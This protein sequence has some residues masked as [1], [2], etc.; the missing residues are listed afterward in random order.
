MKTVILLATVVTTVAFSTLAMAEKK[1][2]LGTVRTTSG[3]IYEDCRLFSA[4]IDG[5]TVFHKHGGAK[6]AF[7]ELPAPLRQ[8]FD[9]DAEKVAAHEKERTEKLRK[10]REEFWE[11]QREVAAAE[12]RAQRE[13]QLLQQVL[14]ASSGG[15]YD[16]IFMPQYLYT[17]SYLGGLGF[18]SLPSYQGG[19]HHHGGVPF[20]HVI[21]PRP[22][23]NVK[24][25]PDSNLGP[26]TNKFS[27]PYG[28]GGI[29]RGNA[30]A[31]P[32]FGIPAMGSLAPSL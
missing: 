7:S 10:Q 18:Q 24:D 5:I 32:R 1:A 23:R 13:N 2:S 26:G 4:D 19:H 16:S 27:R 6:I 15:G 14:G 11:R 25:F 22:H 20:V 3:K 28:H 8:Q 29:P 17:S 9:Y 12:A 31:A 30:P 21:R